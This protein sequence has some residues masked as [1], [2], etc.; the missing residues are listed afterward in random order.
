MTHLRFPLLLPLLCIPFVLAGCDAGGGDTI[1]LST[2]S[3]LEPIGYTFQYRKDEV[4]DG[5]VLVTVPP[6]SDPR[7]LDDILREEAATSRSQ[8]QSAK[9]E[10]VTFKR[11]TPGDSNTGSVS[12]RSKVFQYL[13]R[14]EVHLGSESGPLIA[15]EEPVP[16]PDT[17]APIDMNLGPVGSDVGSVDVTSTLK[18]E[19][20]TPATLDLRVSTPNDIGDPFDE[21]KIEVYYSIEV[22]E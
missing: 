6:N 21:I 10:R 7:S 13:S 9:V 19:S 11:V 17:N 16:V 3:V 2:N 8:I 20:P 4:E 22:P 1:T 14:I 12:S 15:A 5:S 18:N